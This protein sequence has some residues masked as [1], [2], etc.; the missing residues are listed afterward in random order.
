MSYVQ[1]IS[2]IYFVQY[3]IYLISRP[4][5]NKKP[6]T[7]GHLQSGAWAA[8]LARSGRY[9]RRSSVMRARWQMPP[10]GGL[11]FETLTRTPAT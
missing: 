11:N 9:R 4:Q 1:D 2:T 3:F 8:A 6:L 10:S 7:A 5:D